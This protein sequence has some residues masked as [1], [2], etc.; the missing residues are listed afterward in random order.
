MKMEPESTPQ[1]TP[2]GT[3]PESANED[4]ISR[5]SFVQR[6]SGAVAA[7][8]AAQFAVTREARASELS[9]KKNFLLVITDQERAPMWFPPNWEEGDPNANPPVPANLPNTQRLKSF[10]LSFNN[11]F[12]AAAMCTPSRNCMFTGLYVPQHR[13][14]WT[15][16]EDTDQ[17]FEEHQ[18]DPTLPN[19][20]TCLKEAGYDVIYKGKWH[21]SKRVP[22]ADGTYTEDDLSRYGFDEWD[23]PD[24][25]GD[26]RIEN[27]GGADALNTVKHDQRFVD[28]AVAFL[29]DRIANPTDTPFFLIVSLVNPHD[30]LSYPKKYVDSLDNAVEGG[31]KDG[32][33]DS[34]PWIE[35]TNPA[36][37]I[38][39]TIDESLLTN[40][41]PTAQAFLPPLGAAALGLLRTEARQ[42]AYL[43]FYGRLMA[44][45]DTQIGQ[46]LDVLD[47][48][49]DGSGQALRD[50]IVIR[51]SDHGEMGLCHGGMRQK[52]F[53]AYEETVRIPMIWSNPDLFPTAKTTDAMISHVDLLPTLCELTG[54]TDHSFKGVDYSHVILDP[55]SNTAA[56]AVQ[57]YVVFTFDD[58]YSAGDR[59]D[60]GEEGAVPPPNRIQMVRNADFKLVRYYDGEGVEEDQGEFYDLRPSGG[61]YYV[62]DG[63]GGST[64]Y[65]TD[66]PL[67]T[68]NYYWT[69]DIFLD[70]DKLAGR[71]LLTN[72][73][74]TVQATTL[75][76]QATDSSNSPTAKN[77]D[78]SVRRWTDD[79]GTAQAQVE[80]SFFSR[81]NESYQLQRSFDLE[82]W[83]DIPNQVCSD[84]VLDPGQP[85]VGNN[86]RIIFCD[87]L[88]AEKA[89]YRIVQTVI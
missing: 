56:D 88:T 72:I 48:T 59:A 84:E 15:L 3:N 26:A 82:N 39:P 77:P 79:G 35:D 34:D 8:I 66:A 16:T 43:N 74:T 21:M 12:T 30:V 17:A 58:I 22:N 13:S 25:G 29:Q 37:E 75:A 47:P 42:K 19:M 49:G 57:D 10:G 44:A 61:D 50:T 78:I 65:G 5:R 62:N 86:G 7:M 14:D 4:S 80:I 54:V 70:A 71:N 40:F 2:C 33:G 51:T 83:V 87:D 81:E 89:Y 6:S 73:L 38:P 36:I 52:A 27:F 46:L 41:K 18:L 64:I 31:Y 28:D 55:D 1:S 20:A 9:E 85:V 67:E 63:A 68:V 32:Y 60:L 53:V 23:A 76:P 11:A 69:P 24:A 45:V